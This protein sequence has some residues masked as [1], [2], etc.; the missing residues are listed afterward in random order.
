[1]S[2]RNID[3]ERYD[4]ASVIVAQGLQPDEVVV[5]AGVHALHPGQQVTERLERTLQEVPSL[6]AL[7]SY[8][9]AGAGVILVDLVGS[10]Y[11][12]TVEDSCIRC[13]RRS[14]TSAAPSPRG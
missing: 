14:P 9:T 5:T 12:R 10:A 7:R 4:L 6:D 1:M 2:L 8:T 13:A 11:G 3:V